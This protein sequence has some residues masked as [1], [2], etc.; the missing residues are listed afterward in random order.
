M[1]KLIACNTERKKIQSDTFE[2]CKSLVE[3]RYKDDYFLNLNRSMERL[4]KENPALFNQRRK[5]DMILS[6]ADVNL[7]L[8]E[9][10]KLLEPF[11]CD[12]PQPL[13]QVVSLVPE[14]LRRMGTNGQYTKV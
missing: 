14:A 11:G 6:A 4:L 5:A 3:E 1:N 13:V 8:I 7:E 2:I 12:N 9:E 10:M